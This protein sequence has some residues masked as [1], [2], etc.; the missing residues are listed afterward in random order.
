MHRPCL[1][2]SAVCRFQPWQPPATETLELRA[3][4]RRIAAL[5]VF[6]T[7]GEEPAACSR[8]HGAAQP[9]PYVRI[10]S[11]ASSRLEQRI[12]RLI[13]QSL[14]VIDRC[15]QLKKN[16]ELLTSMPGLAEKSGIQVLSEVGDPAAGL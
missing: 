2:S 5:T 7:Q 10:W 4:A 15:P 9:G 1:N 8:R 3:L 6:G 13:E 11:S 14:A 12:D 16:F